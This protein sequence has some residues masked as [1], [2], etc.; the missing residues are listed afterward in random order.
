MSESSKSS[1]ASFL[2]KSFF[3]GLAASG[4]AVIIFDLLTRLP[5]LDSILKPIHDRF[6][7]EVEN[8]I[9]LLI[10]SLILFGLGA[11]ST[12]FTRKA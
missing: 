4:F 8:G 3:Y 11:L 9:G 7:P 5:G 1:S 10:T 12:L 6:F 2:L